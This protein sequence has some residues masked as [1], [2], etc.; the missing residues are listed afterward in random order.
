MNWDYEGEFL[1]AWSPARRSL[2]V[3]QFCNAVRAGA[4]TVNQILEMVGAEAN[5]YW[6]QNGDGG[7]RGQAQRLLLKLIDEPE[8]RKFAEFILRREGLPD[9][10]KRRLK[11]AAGDRYRRDYM[12]KQPPTEKQLGYLRSLGY[13]HTPT[14]RL[15]AS[16]LIEKHKNGN[17]QR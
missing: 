7:E 11:E 17:V 8:T 1:N 5:E 12:E 13:L 15:E 9:E 16:D 10:E 2:I 4:F 3:N 14:N 6:F